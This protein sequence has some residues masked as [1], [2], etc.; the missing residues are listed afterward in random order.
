MRYN[1]IIEI[2]TEALWLQQLKVFYLQRTARSCFTDWRR[3][4]QKYAVRAWN[5]VFY[6]SAKGK[7]FLEKYTKIEGG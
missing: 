6:I 2:M 1:K 4:S 7:F 5:I 3:V